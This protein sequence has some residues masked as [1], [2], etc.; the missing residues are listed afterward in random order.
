[1]ICVS[2][3][4]VPFLS[5]PVAIPADKSGATDAPE[6]FENMPITLQVVGRPFEDEELIS[7]TEVL[8]DLMNYVP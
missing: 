7:V 6:L 8:D 4:R 1:M 3:L 2:I 5:I